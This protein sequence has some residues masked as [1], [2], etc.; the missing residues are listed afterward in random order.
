M[1]IET[2]IGATSRSSDL[3]AGA[4]VHLRDKREYWMAYVLVDGMELQGHGHTPA[5][6]LAE[7]A[8]R[9]DNWMNAMNQESSNEQ[10]AQMLPAFPSLGIAVGDVICDTSI[11]V[12]VK[13]PEQFGRDGRGWNP[14]GYQVRWWIKNEAGVQE[15]PPVQFYYKIPP[16]H[17][18][19][20]DWGAITRDQDKTIGDAENI[21]KTIC[22]A[23]GWPYSPRVEDND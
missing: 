20:S 17:F 21:C 15:M 3:L 16:P 4:T 18:R 10:A 8:C 7:L 13:K 9:I 6:A 1:S 23:K 14:R 12:A 5:I 2:E 19:E 22:E 11:I